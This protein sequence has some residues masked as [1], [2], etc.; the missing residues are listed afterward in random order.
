[1]FI[2]DNTVISVEKTKK[3]FKIIDK[4]EPIRKSKKAGSKYVW[5]G[6]NIILTKKTKPGFWLGIDEKFLVREVSKQSERGHGLTEIRRQKINDWEKKIYIPGARVYHLVRVAVN[7]KLPKDDI[8]GFAQIKSFKF[9]SNIHPV[10]PVWYKKHFACQSRDRCVKSKEWA[11][12]VFLRYL[13]SVTIGEA[14]ISLTNK[15]KYGK[16]TQGDKIDEKRLTYRLVTDEGELDF[17]VKDCTDAGTFAGKEKSYA[18][19][20]LLEMLRRFDPNEV[21]RIATDSIYVQKEA[22]YKIENIPAFFKQVEVKLDPNLCLHYPSCAMCSDPEEFFIS[23]SEYAK[24]IKEFLKT[25]R[26]L[27]L[28][29]QEEQEVRNIQPGQWHDKGEKIYGPVADI[30]LELIKDIPDRGGSGKTIQ[31]IKIFKDISMV[32]FT[33][34]NA[35]AKDFQNDR[36]VKAQTWHSFFR[37]NGVEEWTP[38]QKFIDYLLEQKCQKV[39]TD[40]WAKCSKLYELKKEMHRKNNQSSS[41]RILS[42]YRL[43]R[44]LA[45]QIC[46]K[47]HCT[48]YPEIPIPLIYRPKDGCKQNCL[49]LIPGSSEKREL[50]IDW[51]LGYAMTIHTSQ[52]MTLKASQRVWIEGPSLPPEIEDTKNKKAIEHSLRPFISEK[53]EWD[54]ARNPDQ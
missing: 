49:V 6:P 31:A 15:Q 2:R 10:I 37:W 17:L 48:K 16:F 38:E 46:L 39:L 24:W 32:V 33:H 21:V 11:P 13:E 12:I 22:L 34:T 9:A 19:I 35:L 47:L 23:K 26:P 45:S 20:N 44:R 54:E 28:N 7:G 25:K 36:K 30:A 14:I 52:G 18:Y 53:L 29:Q 41:D 42:A 4:Y 43:F 1:K 40:Y 51:E 50:A 5:G 8:T 27:Q 3:G